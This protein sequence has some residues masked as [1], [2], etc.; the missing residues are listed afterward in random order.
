MTP[1][2]P[3]PLAAASSELGSAFGVGAPDWIAAKAACSP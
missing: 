2:L 1:P 3:L